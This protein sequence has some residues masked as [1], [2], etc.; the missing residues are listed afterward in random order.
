MD[1]QI[2]DEIIAC[3]QGE[4]TVYHYYRDRYGFGLLRQLSRQGG[5][6]LSVA[7]LKKSAYAP[8]LNKPRIKSAL[9][10]L[11][12]DRIDEQFLAAHDHDP[13]QESFV[14]TRAEN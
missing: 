14:L 5:E 12:R 13:D 10:R 6:A 1:R 9:A 11:G 2:I 8:L 7:A 4:R 3:L